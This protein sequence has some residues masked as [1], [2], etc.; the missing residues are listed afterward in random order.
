MTSHLHPPPDVP[1]QIS[2]QHS[3]SERRVT[4]TWSI[5]VLKQKLEPVTGIP[6]AS[7]RLVLSAA[8]SV[9]AQDDRQ[10]EGTRG[11]REIAAAD[12]EGTTLEGWRLGR[13]D[14]IFVYAPFLPPTFSA[15]PLYERW[16]MYGKVHDLRPP[17]ARPNLS[18]TSGV[19]KY[20]LPADEYAALPA[21]VLAWKRA[22]KLGRFDPDAPARLEERAR[23]HEEE[24]RAR[25]LA[26]GRRCRVGMEDTRRGE[27]AFLGPVPEIHAGGVPGGWWV[28]VRLDEPVGRNDGS[29]PS[30][31]SEPTTAE[32]SGQ[33]QG[34]K[35][36]R[37]FDAGGA[38]RGVF[39][40]PDRV[41][42]GAF[43]ALDELAELEEI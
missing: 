39:V 8:G 20:T 2:S 18:D 35:E 21:S 33:G 32:T 27:I 42:A 14:A 9:E 16:L 23:A 29:V 22:Q 43:P 19:Q 3:S 28:G 12:E 17:S 26:V 40:R 38:K 6:A 36:A 37:Y 1:V 7:Q 15:L 11:G 31:S 5:G 41:E 24:A 34:A 13:G 10:A 30:S 25:G 4:P